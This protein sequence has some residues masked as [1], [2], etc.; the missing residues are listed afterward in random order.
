[1]SVCPRPADAGLDDL[2]VW[3]ERTG[4]AGAFT[5]MDGR[6]LPDGQVA[7]V[8][9]P[10]TLERVHDAEALLE[11]L[12]DH[13]GPESRLVVAVSW[14]APSPLGSHRAFHPGSLLALVARCYRVLRLEVGDTLLGVVATPDPDAGRR[15]RA[16]LR[17]LAEAQ[18]QIESHLDDG[19]MAR[20]RARALEDALASADQAVVEAD[21]A[22]HGVRRQRN[23]AR[24]ELRERRAELDDLQAWNERAG[25]RLHEVTAAS[26]ELAAALEKERRGS[27]EL[28]G[29]LERI[30]RS[31]AYRG[32]Q[33]V[34]SLSR[35]FARR[36]GRPG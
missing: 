25:R 35:R 8:S 5:V 26:D 21:R 14:A 27:E 32:F 16:A 10:G 17:A 2:R 4:G 13:V 22:E 28:R 36:T 15:E 1:M 23:A 24:R 29:R 6:R 34:R 31:A 3:C 12:L 18:P 7:S 33:L 19:F 20:L 9:L 30:E 11:G